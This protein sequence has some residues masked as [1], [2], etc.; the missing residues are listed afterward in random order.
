MRERTHMSETATQP[1]T[2]TYHAS[3]IPSTF[4]F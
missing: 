3:P 1:F 2:G 4:A